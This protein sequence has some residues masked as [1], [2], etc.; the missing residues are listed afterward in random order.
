MSYINGVTG[1]SKKEEHEIM[2]A[3][4]TPDGYLYQLQASLENPLPRNKKQ[5]KVK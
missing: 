2:V 3:L 5:R 4:Q 1:I